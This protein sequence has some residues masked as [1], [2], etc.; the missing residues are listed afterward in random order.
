MIYG[1]FFYSFF[2]NINIKIY[3]VHTCLYAAIHAPSCVGCLFGY[4]Q[5]DISIRLADQSDILQQGPVQQ[6]K[7]RKK[8]GILM[9]TFNLWEDILGFFSYSIFLICTFFS[10]CVCGRE[11]GQVRFPQFFYSLAN[12]YTRVNAGVYTV[13][14]IHYTVAPPFFYWTFLSFLLFPFFFKFFFRI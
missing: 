1:P 7:E 5:L 10:L 3:T 4:I 6:Q 12:I 8:K 2:L 13:Q 11:K 9:D 14:H